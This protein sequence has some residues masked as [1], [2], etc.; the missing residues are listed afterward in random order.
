MGGLEPPTPGSR[1]RCAA[2][3][4]HPVGTDGRIRTD[5]D[6]VLSAVP[7]PLGYVSVVDQAGIEPAASSLQRNRRF[8]WQLAQGPEGRWSRGRESNPPSVGY[9]PSPI[10]DP[11]HW[12]GGPRSARIS[13]CRVSTGR[14]TIRA[15][16]PW[17]AREPGNR[18]W[19]PCGCHVE[20]EGTPV[21][22]ACSGPPSPRG[23]AW[24]EVPPFLR[25]GS[26]WTPGRD[27]HPRL[28]V[29][30]HAPRFSATG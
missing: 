25:I 15:S 4:P 12:G 16:G 18:G 26:R 20:G 8:Q 1:S 5:T 14:S 21:F 29:C 22:A 9:E 27:S 6:G 7:L 10:P 13:S 30:S 24:W 23:V 11:P 2:I 19:L 17:L 28:V 3:A